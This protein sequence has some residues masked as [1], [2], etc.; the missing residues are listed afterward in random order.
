MLATEI[1]RTKSMSLIRMLWKWLY[2]QVIFSVN[3]IKKLSVIF[4]SELSHLKYMLSHEDSKEQKQCC[5]GTVTVPDLKL[6][7]T[8]KRWFLHWPMLATGPSCSP[9]Q[10]TERLTTS[11]WAES[12]GQISWPWGSL[13]KKV[14]KNWKS[15][16][17]WMTAAKPCS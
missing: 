13:K 17:Q 3:A 16:G 4:L 8:S 15:Q 14:Q 1:K 10:W 5:V 11:H 7:L 2:F 12:K 9:Y 6:E